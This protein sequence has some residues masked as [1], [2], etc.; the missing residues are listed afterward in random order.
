[1]AQRDFVL[2]NRALFVSKECWQ[3][4]RVSSRIVVGH[5]EGVAMITGNAPRITWNWRWLSR[6]RE[7]K[8]REENV[9]ESRIALVYI[10]AVLGRI[11]ID[12]TLGRKEIFCTR[13]P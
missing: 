12:A 6:A 4:T 13:D 3:V 11:C 9:E 5:V 7:D 1:M 10:V 2:E 8:S